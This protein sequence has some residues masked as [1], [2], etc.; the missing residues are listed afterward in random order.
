MTQDEVRDLIDKYIIKNSMGAI[1]AVIMR[2][3][4]EEILNQPNALIGKLEYLDTLEKTTI[5]DA[6]NSIVNGQIV[7]INAKILELIEKDVE[8]DQRLDLVEQ[9]DRDQDGKIE[10]I[11]EKNT[12]QDG[13][14][15]SIENHDASQDVRLDVIELKNEDQDEEIT[16]INLKDNAQDIQIADLQN[17]DA[18]QDVKIEAIEAVNEIQNS[19]LT[20]VEGIN[21]DQDIEIQSLKN[22]DISQDA[23]IQNLK[24]KDVLQDAEIT[25]LDNRVDTLENKVATVYIPKGSVANITALFALTNQGIGWVYN[26]EDTGMNYVWLGGNEG[27]QGNG[28][29]SLGGW[30]DFSEYYTRL[31]VDAK[32]GAM[33]LQ[34]VTDLG[35]ITT[36]DIRIINQNEERLAILDS[37][38]IILSDLA[39]G[40]NTTLSNTGG[41][42]I[43]EHSDNGI[44]NGLSINKDR[45]VFTKVVQG[46]DAE[47]NLDFTTLQQ[48]TDL[49]EQGGGGSVPTL[50]EVIEAG[51]ISTDG[52]MIGKPLSSAQ[53][54][55]YPGYVGIP[56][57]SGGGEVK[58]DFD[59]FEISS[60]TENLQL[61]NQ[62]LM[63]FG[64]H[65][66]TTTFKSDF[67]GFT[68]EYNSSQRGLRVAQNEEGEGELY[69]DIPIGGQPATSPL[70]LVTLS[71]VEEKNFIVSADGSKW[72]IDD[73]GNTY[74]LT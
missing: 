16:L 46:V 6:I 5:V 23:E 20:S 27:D 44:T 53:T 74:K 54:N 34:R 63:A 30:V 33:D 11:E 56:I 26:L 13:R 50:Q 70:H 35:N 68:F 24:D 37:D 64:R 38:D 14:L 58:M 36:N 45:T 49:I 62:G 69:F 57:Q 67:I 9:H 25:D 52:F 71:Q 73:A 12:E 61:G 31:E 60:N 42:T 10:A 39:N 48:V 3:I 66:F 19:R 29:D 40:K 2:P 51:N 18:L 22:K 55:I 8:Q 43:L 41:N 17:K 1:T 28:W 72:G 65:G 4:L 59:G 47:D 32:L 21:E 7:E 15:D